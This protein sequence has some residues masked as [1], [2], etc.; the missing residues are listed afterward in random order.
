MKDSS[1]DL[2][3][4]RCADQ[5]VQRVN[6]VL[7]QAYKL[8]Q[9][10]QIVCIILRQY[11]LAIAGGCLEALWSTSDDEDAMQQLQDAVGDRSTH[12]ARRRLDLQENTAGG[13]AAAL[14]CKQ[15]PL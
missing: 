2:L 13:A 4:E 15:Q 3:V 9:L 6:S 5:P 12:I 10:L 7:I 14:R 1:T 11:A 8:L